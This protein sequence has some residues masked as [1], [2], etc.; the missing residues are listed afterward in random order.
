MSGPSCPAPTGSPWRPEGSGLAWWEPIT[1]QESYLRS[2]RTGALGI[3]SNLVRRGVEL[4]EGASVSQGWAP[5]RQVH[6][7][8]SPQT[9]ALVVQ[10]V[11]LEHPLALEAPEN[12]EAGA[13]PQ[14]RAQW[15][16]KLPRLRGH[17]LLQGRVKRL[18]PWNTGNQVLELY[19]FQGDP[20]LGGWW[21]CSSLLG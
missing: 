14:Q 12:L 9:T 11:V 7:P 8:C 4:L 21:G 18:Q 10:R 6:R 3:P 13:A 20:G 2:V 19:P 16:G 15:L 17:R 5:R 1:Y